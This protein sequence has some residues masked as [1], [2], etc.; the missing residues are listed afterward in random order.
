MFTHKVVELSY[1]E[2]QLVYEAK[3]ASK[4]AYCPASKYS[5]GAALKLDGPE[6]FT[7]ANIEVPC[8]QTL[9]AERV[10]II[11]V[12]M[13]PKGIMLRSKDDGQ[14]GMMWLVVY[15]KDAAPSCGICR[16][17]MSQFAP[18]DLRVVS[19]DG[20]MAYH[21]TLKELYPYPFVR[22]YPDSA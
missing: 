21:R 22:V 10:A 16:H 1:L 6:I 17:F 4:K 14:L 15:T 19:T 9:C 18:L 11:S 3:R 12:L 8:G 7:G 20:V 2:Q 5:V 13:S